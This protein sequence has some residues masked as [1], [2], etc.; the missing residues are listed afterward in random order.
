MKQ[1]KKKINKIKALNGF[2]K[3]TATLF[4]EKIPQF[5]EFIENTNLQSKL[6][7]FIKSNSEEKKHK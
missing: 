7:E 2:A 5:M 6:E 1:V 3:K 4:V